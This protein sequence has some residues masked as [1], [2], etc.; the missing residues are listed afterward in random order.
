MKG[1]RRTLFL[2]DIRFWWFYLLELLICAVAFGDLILPALGIA[3]PFSALTAGW[4]FPIVALLARL[5][6]YWL[7]KPRM[8]VTYALFYQQ[9]CE[10][11]HKEP[12]PAKPKRM[13]WTY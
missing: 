4:V 5:A 11:G 12:E 8:A 3:L 13:P 7:A 1:Y 10:G 9:V 6:L 2:L